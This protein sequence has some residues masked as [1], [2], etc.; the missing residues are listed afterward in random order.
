[1]QGET[2]WHTHED[3]D[4]FSY[5]LDGRLTIDVQGG[6]SV[7]LGPQEGCRVREGVTDRA[8][9]DERAAVMMLDL[10]EGDHSH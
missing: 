9:A 8:C 4:G 5:V 1:M 10:A 6:K 2:P 7:T 3:E